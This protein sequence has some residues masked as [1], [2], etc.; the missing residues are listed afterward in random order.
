[1]LSDLKRAQTMKQ[2]G[3]GGWEMC[4]QN[5]TI[6]RGVNYEW[7]PD[8]FWNQKIEKLNWEFYGK[9]YTTD[10]PRQKTESTNLKTE[11]LKLPEQRIKKKN[12]WRK[13]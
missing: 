11:L 1:M 6:N 4:E 10:L 7:K 3:G 12:Q 9:D 13:M 5:D 8:K 2:N